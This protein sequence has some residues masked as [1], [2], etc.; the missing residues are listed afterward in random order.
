MIGRAGEFAGFPDL[1]EDPEH[2]NRRLW[3]AFPV[4]S[5]DGLDF[6]TQHRCTKAMKQTSYSSEP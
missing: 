3:T 2:D 5:P 4:K 1:V 6:D